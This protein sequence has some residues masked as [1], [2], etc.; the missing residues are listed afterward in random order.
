MKSWKDRYSNF[1]DNSVLVKHDLIVFL[2]LLVCLAA[3]FSYG[4]L[5]KSEYSFIVGTFKN[6]LVDSEYSLTK[7]GTKSFV[8]KISKYFNSHLN[9]IYIQRSK[10]EVLRIWETQNGKYVVEKYWWN[11]RLVKD[12][13]T[14]ISENK[15][16][17]SIDMFYS[18]GGIF[19]TYDIKTEEKDI[20]V[21]SWKE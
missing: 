19:D 9:S 5:N 4:F 7:E 2:I 12:L 14:N 21:N 18:S 6:G 15:M 8:E 1:L 17:E 3:V 11:H 10:N 20:S 16:S 13:Y